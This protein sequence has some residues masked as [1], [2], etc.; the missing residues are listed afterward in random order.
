MSERTLY[1]SS[2]ILLSIGVNF[3][4]LQ[5]NSAWDALSKTRKERAEKLVGALQA[6]VPYQEGLQVRWCDTPNPILSQ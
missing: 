3:T 5:L 6:A 2:N 1:S 4:Y